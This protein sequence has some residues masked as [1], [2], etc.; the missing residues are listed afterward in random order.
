MYILSCNN[1]N[2]NQ[3][4][5]LDARF[6]KSDTELGPEAKVRHRFFGRTEVW[7]GPRCTEKV[8]R[9]ERVEGLSP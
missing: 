5:R 7:I 9:P 2:G 8:T 1:N 6:L 3:I 4:N